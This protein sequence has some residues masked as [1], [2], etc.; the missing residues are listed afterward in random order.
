VI[1]GGSWNNNATNARVSYRNNNTPG[2]INNNIGFRLACSSK[3]RIDFEQTPN[4]I[5]VKRVKT[6]S[7]CPV[8]R[9]TSKG[10]QDFFMSY[11][12]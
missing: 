11:I 12:R 1:R 6:T 2:N 9:N 10:G 3:Q 5:S 4:P 7:S 8:S